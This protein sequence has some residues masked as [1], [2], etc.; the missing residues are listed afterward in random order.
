MLVGALWEGFVMAARW[1]KDETKEGHEPRGSEWQ[2]HGSGVGPASRGGESRKCS[3][4]SR[5]S[6]CCSASRFSSCRGRRPRG[7]KAGTDGSRGKAAVGLHSGGEG[8]EWGCTK[9]E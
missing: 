8:F 9:R 2:E 5:R 6:L 7:M 4:R 3:H 1:T